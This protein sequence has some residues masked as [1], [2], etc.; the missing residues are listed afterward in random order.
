M[1]TI[2][3][4]MSEPI[5]RDVEF[6]TLDGTTLRGWFYPAGE[7]AP[8]VI[9]SHGFACLKS[10]SLPALSTA[11]Q[12]SGIASLLYDQ[13]CFGTSSGTP[14][15]D[16]DPDLQSSDVH[17]AISH[18]LTLPGVNH[19]KIGIIG[20]SYSSAHAIKAASLDRRIKTVISL[21]SF[22]R[23]AW[24]LGLFVSDRPAT[25]ALIWKDRERQRIGDGEVGYFP[26]VPTAEAPGNA[27]LPADDAAEFYLRMQK[28][29]TE[30]G[31]EWENRVTTRSLL[32][33][34][35]YNVIED[36]KA[37]APTSL[38]MIVDE[39]VMGSGEYQKAFEAAGEGGE[40]LKEFVTVPGA[41]F[42]VLAEGKGLEKVIDHSIRFLKKVFD[43]EEGGGEGCDTSV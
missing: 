8:A 21:S 35:S 13:R 41:H 19:D 29:E 20:Y 5:R 30:N 24:L 27:F 1:T 16:V 2:T 39:A 34:R 10:W 9:I 15:H 40:I 22:L 7:N 31:G 4:P 18:L 14:R 32:K 38:L 42:D 17:D 26:V 43:G 11:L 12:S 6:K 28:V 3:T 25:D 36:L 23:G 37:L 33:M